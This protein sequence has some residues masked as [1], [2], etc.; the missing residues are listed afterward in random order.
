[1]NQKVSLN[2]EAQSNFYS[3]WQEQENQSAQC[4]NG[5]NNGRSK[6][7]TVIH[8]TEGVKSQAN[9]GGPHSRWRAYA[10]I[11]QPWLWTSFGPTG[12]TWN[13][14][15]SFLE[16]DTSKCTIAYTTGASTNC[17]RR[18]QCVEKPTT[19]VGIADLATG[20]GKAKCFYMIY[21]L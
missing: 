11:E 2:W 6:S 7:S 3:T 18:H 5:P 8:T 4:T 16:V 15:R 12:Q 9:L 13:P 19:P 1:M 14:H 21:V 17:C 20:A 10:L